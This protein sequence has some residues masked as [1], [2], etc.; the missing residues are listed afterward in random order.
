[1][2][3]IS[4]HLWISKSPV[5]TCLDTLEKEIRIFIQEN[6]LRVCFNFKSFCSVLFRN[7]TQTHCLQR[8]CASVIMHIKNRM[9]MLVDDVSKK[10]VLKT[11]RLK[12]SLPWF[13]FSAAVQRPH[14]HYF[15]SCWWGPGHHVSYSLHTTFALQT[16]MEGCQKALQVHIGIAKT[17]LNEK[18]TQV[19]SP[20]SAS[21]QHTFL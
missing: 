20:C 1:M 17:V 21:T 13:T 11:V 10:S 18:K 5:Y 3:D 7:N 14:N 15:K 2:D 6:F 9:T 16:H 19:Q 4:E 8:N 12:F